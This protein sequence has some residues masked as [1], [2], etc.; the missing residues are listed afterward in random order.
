MSI[1]NI[2]VCLCGVMSLALL[3]SHTNA[4]AACPENTRSV[5]VK[6][7]IYNNA[8]TLGST[9]GTVHLVYGKNEKIKCG[10]LGSGGVGQDGA[11]SFIHTI[12]CD[13]KFDTGINNE[14]I[15]SQLTLNTSGSGVFQL[16]D[17]GNPEGGVYGA[18]YETSVPLFGRGVFQ[19]VAGGEISIEGSINCQFAVDMDF[20]GYICLPSR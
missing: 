8:I 13:D 19:N 16:C 11:L 2:E 20:N 15:H 10:I 12:V 4:G 6:G 17:S 1:R 7:K 5:D 3:I 9:L 14:I 18:F